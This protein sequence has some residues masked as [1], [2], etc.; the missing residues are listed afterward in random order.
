MA[1]GL[2]AVGALDDTTQV[3]ELHRVALH[4]YVPYIGIAL[5]GIFGVTKFKTREVDIH[6]FAIAMGSILL[7]N[8]LAVGNLTLAAFS[9]GWKVEDVVHFAEDI[10]QVL[11]I[12]PAAAIGYYFG[13]QTAE[14][15]R[16]NGVKGAARTPPSGKPVLPTV[17]AP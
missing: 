12:L 16:G 11:T 2:Y 5:G 14:P 13:V 1:W 6:V 7:W 4:L 3:G 10:M 17:P 9:E 15:A 8:V